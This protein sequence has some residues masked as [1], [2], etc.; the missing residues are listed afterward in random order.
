M[1]KSL[2]L[3]LSLVLYVVSLLRRGAPRTTGA[4]MGAQM[5]INHTFFGVQYTGAAG[6]T[7]A[8]PADEP[9]PTRRKGS[10]LVTL[11]TAFMLSFMLLIAL[12]RIGTTVANPGGYISAIAAYQ[13]IQP[14][15]P[16]SALKPHTCG[17]HYASPMTYEQQCDVTLVSDAFRKVTLTIEAGKLKKVTLL[18]QHAKV[19]DLVQVWGRPDSIIQEH[20]IFTMRWEGGILAT[21]AGRS[22]FNYLLPVKT[23]VLS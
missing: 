15:I 6:R 17:P 9:R 18:S 10:L 23:V 16:Y 1:M 14:S 19:G 11:A 12:T 13:S 7:R 2:A 3:I 21:A 8:I 4:S 22:W 5:R 20:G